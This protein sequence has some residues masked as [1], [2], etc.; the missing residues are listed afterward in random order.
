MA[1]GPGRRKAFDPVQ[2]HHLGAIFAGQGIDAVLV[3][4]RAG[5]IA[6][7]G[8]LGD[9]DVIAVKDAQQRFD[10]AQVGDRRARYAAQ[11]QPQWRRHQVGFEQ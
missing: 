9:G 10:K 2:V 1:V 7:D 5:V 6:W 4:D 11:R 3:Q 8:A